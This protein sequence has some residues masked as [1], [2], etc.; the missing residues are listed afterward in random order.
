MTRKKLIIFSILLLAAL[1]TVISLEV[2]SK[3]SALEATVEQKLDDPQ[4]V[5]GEDVV[6]GFKKETGLAAKE[7]RKVE[8]EEEAEQ[9]ANVA[10]SESFEA[11]TVLD[12]PSSPSVN[13]SSTESQETK[14][15]RS[16]ATSTTPKSQEKKNSQTTENK[17]VTEKSKQ[18]KNS[19]YKEDKKEDK[20]EEKKQ[21]PAPPPETV[22]LTIIGSPDIGT[23]LA[24]VEV[25][26]VNNDTVLE[27]LKRETRAR[28]IHMEFRG[29]GATAYVEGINNLYEFDRG[30]GS[31]WMYSINGKFPNRSAGIWPVKAGE[32]IRWLYT[33]DLGKDIGGGVD[34][35]LWDG[36]D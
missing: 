15:N 30:P 19:A 31:G 2:I 18:E 35:G 14:T 21:E 27:V 1:T 36:E 29:R 5:V 25:E 32:H 10:T 16:K 20:K 28:Q 22:L 13:T 7:N 8:V 34:D 4:V 11:D 24:T 26:I 6:Q 12:Q 23:I 9:E 3:N 17:Q 33:E